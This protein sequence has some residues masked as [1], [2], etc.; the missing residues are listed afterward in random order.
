MRYLFVFFL[1]FSLNVSA[2]ETPA[3]AL[4]AM[5]VGSYESKGYS[6]QVV[7]LSHELKKL[8]I[9]QGNSKIFEGVFRN[10]SSTQFISKDHSFML[11]S[12][13]KNEK[14]VILSIKSIIGASFQPLYVFTDVSAAGTALSSTESLGLFE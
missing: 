4:A 10:L 11:S 1:A 6:I 5:K 13:G 2:N 8:I 9:T 7:P 12:N 14:R 3:Q